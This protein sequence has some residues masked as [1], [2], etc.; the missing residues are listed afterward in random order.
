MVPSGRSYHAAV[1]VTLED[2]QED[3]LVLVAGSNCTGWFVG[4][5]KSIYSSRLT[6]VFSQKGKCE[7]YSDVWIWKA[8]SQ[9]WQIVGAHPPLSTRYDPHG[10]KKFDEISTHFPVS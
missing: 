6:A 7:L 9:Q 5:Q 3:A 1:R 4:T 2:D 10:V 8:S